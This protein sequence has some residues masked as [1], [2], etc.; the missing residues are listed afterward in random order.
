MKKMHKK[1]REMETFDKKQTMIEHLS[2]LRKRLIY[3]ISALLVL[4][5]LAYNFAEL[6]VSDMIN[7]APDINFVFI[8]PAELFMSYI[9]IALIAGFALALPWILYNIWMFLKPGLEID[10]RRLILRALFIGS[11][12]FVIGVLFGYII[13]LPLTINFFTNFKIE[14]IK[15]MISFSNYLS[16][17][18]TFVLSFGLI[19]E[20][21]IVMTILV[22]LGITNTQV[23]KQNRRFAIVI[24]F[25]LAAVLT[26]PDVISQ[27]FLA[28]P[29]LILFEVGLYFSRLVE[30]KKNDRLEEEG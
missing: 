6:I 25:T 5:I 29:M 14:G 11:F 1:D 20:L 28:I 7:K 18:S 16:F 4:T 12:L 27:T 26:P 3:S 2:E 19:F 15:P 10:E 30:G 17:A 23:L 21:P 8:A 13:V 24:I 9:K 22:K